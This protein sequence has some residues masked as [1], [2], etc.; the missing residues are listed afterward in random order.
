[1]RTI[2]HGSLIEPGTARMIAEVGAYVVP[3]LSAGEL[4]AGHVAELELPAS[5]ANR[6]REVNKNP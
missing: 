2:E 6:V 3:T 1:M 4:I 5:A